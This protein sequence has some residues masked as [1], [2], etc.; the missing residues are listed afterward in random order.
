MTYKICFFDNCVLHYAYERFL[1]KK[2][3]AD[4]NDAYFDRKA[5]SMRYV[6]VEFFVLEVKP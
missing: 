5:L 6:D 2:E 4:Y 1:C 3:Y